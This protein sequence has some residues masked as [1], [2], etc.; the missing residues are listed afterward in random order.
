MSSIERKL[1]AQSENRLQELSAKR[2]ELSFEANKA[3]LSGHSG[4]DRVC[5]P[6]SSATTRPLATEM[7]A[8]GSSAEV[9]SK[10]KATV[11]TVERATSPLGHMQMI[12]YTS[13][14]VPGHA[15]QTGEEQDDNFHMLTAEIRECARRA[16]SE[17]EMA[18]VF[19]NAADS[20]E[21]ETFISV[22]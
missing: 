4:H 15:M 1:K 13:T 14:H 5:M 12:P 19:F 20:S 9:A 2:Q 7:G 3:L 21:V 10:F 22:D 18:M 6:I 17:L 11:L 8:G 16:A